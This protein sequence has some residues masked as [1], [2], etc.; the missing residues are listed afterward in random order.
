MTRPIPTLAFQGG[1]ERFT[2]FRGEKAGMRAVVTLSFLQKTHK[3]DAFCPHGS[4]NGRTDGEIAAR[5]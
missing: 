2:F 1:G 3:N 4:K 5:K